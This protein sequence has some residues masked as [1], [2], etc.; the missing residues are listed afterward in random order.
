MISTLI[1]T[2]HV[3]QEIHT[4][5]FNHRGTWLFQL[6]KRNPIPP[7]RIHSIL[8][9]WTTSSRLTWILTK[10]SSLSNY[11]NVYS[12]VTWMVS[13]TSLR[14][15]VARRHQSNSYSNGFSAIRVQRSTPWPSKRLRRSATGSMMSLP[16][17]PNIRLSMPLKLTS[18]KKCS[19][20]LIW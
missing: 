6:C 10:S 9:I 14:S 3:F 7:R 18:R 17:S 20:H 11:R 4:I 8:S 12:I 13:E 16:T 5:F 19:N 1:A 15:R 2:P